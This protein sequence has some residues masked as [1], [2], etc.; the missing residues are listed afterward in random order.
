MSVTIISQKLGIINTV[1]YIILILCLCG[2]Q[3]GMVVV[4]V[5]MDLQE[6][7]LAVGM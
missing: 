4:L 7:Q 2:R 6:Y 3:L 5:L 1:W